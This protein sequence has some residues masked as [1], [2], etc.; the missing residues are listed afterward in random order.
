MSDYGSWRNKATGQVI[1]HTSS[2]VVNKSEGWE[3]C[4]TGGQPIHQGWS[5]AS[6]DAGGIDPFVGGQM[7]GADPR[8]RRFVLWCVV[9][10]GL[11]MSL[12]IIW[13][14]AEA[15]WAKLMKADIDARKGKPTVRSATEIKWSPSVLLHPKQ[16]FEVLGPD[17]V[18]NGDIDGINLDA[19]S[20]LTMNGN[21]NSS[22]L[23]AY[24]TLTVGN[25]SNSTLEAHKIVITGKAVNVKQ[26]IL[27]PYEGIPFSKRPH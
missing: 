11:V 25:V 7:L 18:V 10:V 8:F 4:D 19:F 23:V 3:R 5:I 13:A 21:V 17:A 27:R 1:H 9:A 22:H 16:P 15:G 14:A 26:V 2:S 12:V 20:N 24:N 6:G